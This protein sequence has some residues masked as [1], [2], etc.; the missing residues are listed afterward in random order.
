MSWGITRYQKKI[1][2]S[3]RGHPE[4][5]SKKSCPPK[6]CAL[7]RTM[8]RNIIQIKKI[9]ENT[10][11]IQ[12]LSCLYLNESSECAE[13]KNATF[14]HKRIWIFQ[15]MDDKSKIIDT[16]NSSNTN[17]SAQWNRKPM[18]LPL[19]LKLWTWRIWIW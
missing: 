16:Q 14:N 6:S 2:P 7:M 11:L 17:N 9:V 18:L 19:I 4:V 12:T 3:S 10:V 1:M 15:D 13:S 5:F 8:N